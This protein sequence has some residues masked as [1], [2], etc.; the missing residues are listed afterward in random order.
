MLN[1]TLRTSSQ[2]SVA[3]IL[4]IVQD[5][6]TLFSPWVAWKLYVYAN[7]MSYFW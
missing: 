3:D 4:E 5:D 2:E 1:S 6:S 7:I